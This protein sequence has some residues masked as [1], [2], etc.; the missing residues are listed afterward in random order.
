MGVEKSFSFKKR[1]QKTQKEIN[2][3]YLFCQT[4]TAGTTF[5]HPQPLRTA[6]ET[7]SDSASLRRT[8]PTIL[9]FLE[10]NVFAIL[11]NENFG[12]K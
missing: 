12:L 2:P 6:K 1:T 4:K 9:A 5:K 3:T 8:P 10:F 7:S 11:P